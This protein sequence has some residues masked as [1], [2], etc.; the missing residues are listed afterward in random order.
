MFDKKEFIINLNGNEIEINEYSIIHILNRHF[1]QTTKP[2][3]KKS[4]HIEDIEPRYLNKQ[5]KSIFD[6]IDNSKLLV[7]KPINKVA[8]RYKNIDYQIWINERTKSLKGLGNV[9]YNRLET[10]YP[11]KEQGDIDDLNEN[12]KFEHVNVDLQVYVKK[13]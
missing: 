9:K 3:T 6:D 8:F 4:F 11:V 5:L 1:A 7:D 10:F 13:N 12:Y 2:L